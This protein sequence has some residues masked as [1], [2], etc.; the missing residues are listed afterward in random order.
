RQ[1][2]YG[3][4]AARRWGGWGVCACVWGP[5]GGVGCAS[6]VGGGRVAGSGWGRGHWRRVGAW[7][8]GV[9]WENEAQSRVRRFPSS[10]LFGVLW[11]LLCCLRVCLRDRKSTRLNSSHV[12]ISYAVFCLKKKKKTQSASS[13]YAAH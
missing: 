6:G 2:A 1:G 8:A 11:C 13:H 4:C 12:K 5:L 9:G 10:S 3:G 7:R